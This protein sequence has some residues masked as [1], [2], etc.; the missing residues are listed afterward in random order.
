MACHR[1]ARECVCV[2]ALRERDSTLEGAEF[3]GTCGGPSSG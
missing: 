2:C 1:M 3:T